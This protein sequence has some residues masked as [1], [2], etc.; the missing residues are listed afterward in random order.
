MKY[1]KQDIFLT[2]PTMMKVWTDCCL[3]VYQCILNKPVNLYEKGHMDTEN[4]TT[5]SEISMTNHDVMLIDKQCWRKSMHT[6]LS[7]LHSMLILSKS[8]RNVAFTPILSLASKL[9]SFPYNWHGVSI[10]M[11]LEIKSFVFFFRSNS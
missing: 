10:T 5:R 7:V 11:N 1:W 4:A 3:W 6:H 2:F 8:S 9:Q